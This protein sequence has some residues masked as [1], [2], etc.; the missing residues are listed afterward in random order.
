MLISFLPAGDD[1]VASSRIRVH[2]VVEALRRQGAGATTHY[3]AGADALVIQKRVTPERIAV[4]RSARRSGQLLIYDCD[5]YGAALSL[6][7]KEKDIRLM[8]ELADVV[9]T[10]TPEF[11]SLYRDAYGARRIELVP[12]V[13]DYYLPS[14]LP[15]SELPSATLTVLWFGNATNLDLLRPYLAALSALPSCSLIVCTDARAQSMLDLNANMRFIPWSQA[16][17]PTVLRSAHISFLPHAESGADY[18]K[19]N[20]RMATS[21]AWGVPAVV[22]RTPAYERT[23]RGAGILDACFMNSA[24]ARDAIE[25][26]RDP[27]GRAEYIHKAQPIVWRTHSPEA[28]AARWLEVVRQRRGPA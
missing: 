22:S 14:P 12:D 21:I 16:G 25:R 23:A 7:A 13:V 10:N 9:T 8:F 15:V 11:A 3:D 4:A 26:L 2:S 5:D 24:E 27:P 19:S 6:W 18:A 1:R 28:V 17:F 20:N